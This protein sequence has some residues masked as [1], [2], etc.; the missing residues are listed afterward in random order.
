LAAVVTA[1]IVLGAAVYTVGAVGLALVAV[2]DEEYHLLP[3]AVVWPL[4]LVGVAMAAWAK[5]TPWVRK[6][7]DGE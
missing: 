4:A 6:D 5:A 3:L 1:V 7:P 2:K